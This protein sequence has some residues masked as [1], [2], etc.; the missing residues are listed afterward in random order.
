MGIGGGSPLTGGDDDGRGV[1]VC[2]LAGPPSGVLD[3][4][5]ADHA[6]APK[7]HPGPRHQ[8]RSPASQ[9]DPTTLTGRGGSQPASHGLGA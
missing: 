3:L 9:T 8:G 7:Q 6:R 2:L 5:P 4:E 1:L